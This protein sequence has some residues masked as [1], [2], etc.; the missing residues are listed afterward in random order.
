MWGKHPPH[1]HGAGALCSSRGPSKRHHRPGRPH[2]PFSQHFGALDAESLCQVI[3]QWA[4]SDEPR[5]LKV[6]VSLEQLALIRCTSTLDS[7]AQLSV[8]AVNEASCSCT[9]E[10]SSSCPPHHHHVSASCT[11][12]PLE[13]CSCHN[14][15]LSHMMGKVYSFSWLLWGGGNS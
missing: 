7:L 8:W 2:G 1:V 12:Q 14:A 13:C 6:N 4:Q 11:S 5:Q 15:P 3:Q 10:P 9:V